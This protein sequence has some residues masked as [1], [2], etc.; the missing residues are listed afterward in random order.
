VSRRLVYHVR[1]M[2]TFWT[3][4]LIP[5]LREAPGDAEVPS[6]QLMLRAGLIRKVGSGMYSYLPLGW[7]SLHK[8]MTI[9]REEMAAAGAEEVFLPA[10]IPLD[11][12]KQTGRDVAYGDN[13]FR[14][15]DRHGREQALGPTH[16]EVITDL[17]GSTISSH[18][19]L[20]K[21]LYQI[22][23]KFRDEFRPRFGVLRSREFQMKDAYSFHVALD[24]PGGLSETYQKQFD[25]YCR[26]FQRCG[27][28]YETV[29]AESGPIGGSASH[30]FMVPSPT[31]EDTILK[32]DKGTP[33]SDYAANVE[34]C[35][36]GKRE[37]SASF[38][39]GT[40][41]AAAPTGELEKIHTPNTPGIDDVVAFFKKEL[42]TKLKP[43]NMLKTLVY[44]AEDRWLL[45][46]VRGDH[47]VNEGKLKAA[48]GLTPS[49]ADTAAAKA[50]GFAI[51]FVGPHMAAQR[52]CVIVI[53]PDAAVDQFWVTGANEVDHHVKHFHWKRDVLD[54]LPHADAEPSLPG[55]KRLVVADI[56]NAVD[57]D[58]SP[59]NDGGILRTTKGIEIGHVFKL[60]DK[61]TRAM[62]VTVLDE[63]N[64]RIHPI[65]GCY[66]IGVNRIL[67]AAIEREGGSD[68]D[69]IRWPAAIAPYAVCITTIKYAPGT[70]A[71]DV[72]LQ[73]AGAIEASGR[74]VIIDDRDERP[75][76]K[77]KD[78]DLIGFPIRITIGDKAL[79]E[80]K[81][82]VK[83]RAPGFG[84]MSDKGQLVPIADAPAFVADALSRM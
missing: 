15:K 24:G 53:D 75:G 10:V 9:I 19:D 35:E 76:V 71:T 78:A 27:L 12:F 26:I 70:R 37:Y 51:G 45:A 16:E 1:P 52:D 33:G 84:S 32:S 77:F 72:A 61:Y 13:L 66:G 23:T 36:T 39:D 5:T 22:Q 46:V 67:A 58:P 6:H 47:D 48:C 44:Q 20:P 74:D 73:L 31:G 40:L 29:E 80:D 83:A 34:K 50:A 57:G 42:G 11:L 68:K 28:P 64:Q 54:N 62:N 56:R 17:V 69:G 38:S 14:L 21:T 4:T 59:K 2:P 63:N 8:A 30:E 60:G 65:M 55:A 25:A 79:A 81:V 82:E 41:P 18:K 49:L 43:S 3:Q 7:R